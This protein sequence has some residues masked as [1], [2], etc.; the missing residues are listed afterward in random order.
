MIDAVLRFKIAGI[1]R[2]PMLIQCRTDL[3]IPRSRRL[4]VFFWVAHQFILH[5]GRIGPDK[6]DCR[7]GEPWNLVDYHIDSE[8]MRIPAPSQPGATLHPARGNIRIGSGCKL[9]LRWYRRLDQTEDAPAPLL[10]LRLSAGRRRFR[11]ASSENG[12]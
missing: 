1:R 6:L 9:W 8:F 2:R 12:F 7:Q 10:L 11:S 4:L 3:L 5:P